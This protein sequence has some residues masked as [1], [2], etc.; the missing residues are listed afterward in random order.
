[1]DGQ[2]TLAQ[3]FSLCTR[4]YWECK[5]IC[6]N[7]QSKYEDKPI[8]ITPCEYYDSICGGIPPYE[9]LKARYQ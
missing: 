9:E 4:C 5:G 2:I 1:M 8:P 7:W 3:T 6:E